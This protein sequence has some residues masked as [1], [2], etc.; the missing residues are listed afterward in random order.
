LGARRIILIAHTERAGNKLLIQFL[1]PIQGTSLEKSF[2]SFIGHPASELGASLGERKRS[3]SKRI[4]KRQTWH[5]LMVP[6]T[7]NFKGSIITLNDADTL[8]ALQRPKIF[9]NC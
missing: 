5:L 8:I 7:Q 2:F 4:D 9:G 3:Q 6:H 1:T